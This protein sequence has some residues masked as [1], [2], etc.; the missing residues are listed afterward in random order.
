MSKLLGR[1]ATRAVTRPRPIVAATVF[2]AVIGAVLAAA[3][4]S[5]D[6]GTRTL[7][8]SGSAAFEGTER[9]KERFG[10]DAVVVLVKGD[11]SQLV[12]GDDLGR[13]LGL[14]GC[15]SGQ[16]PPDQGTPAGVCREIAALDPVR[17][18]YGPATFLNQS[19][20]QANRFLDEQTRAALDDAR[21]A[22]QRAA[23]SAAERGA[24]PDEQRRESEAAA[25]AVLSEYG[26]EIV[27]L[28]AEF[29]QTGLPRLDDPAFVSAIVFDSR[30]DDGTPKARF[31][32]LFP[33][34]EAALI[35]VRLRPELSDDER[36]RAIDL[37]R[38]AVTDDRFRL[39]GG[40]YV[41]SGVPVVL[42]GLADE[43]V[44]ETLV[45]LAIALVVMALVLMLVFGRPLRL[46][47]LAIALAASGL[48][49][50]L[51]AALGGSLTMASVAVLPVLIGLAVDYA[52]QLHARYTEA[53]AG[54]LVPGRAAV[55][56]AVSGGPV[57]G[58]AAIATAA[59]FA[60]LFGSP[61]PMVRGFG[62]MLVAGVGFAFA[63]A[64]TAGLGALSL[65]SERELDPSGS[66]RPPRP[67]ARGRV[68]PVDRLFVWSAVVR[69]HLRA[70]LEVAGRRVRGWAKA[71]LA[72]SIGA[73]IRV[74]LI[75]AVLAV[76]G[77]AAGTRTEVVS[78][79]RE[80][81]PDSLPAIEAVDELQ[82]ATGVSGEIDVLISGPG[83]TDPEAIVW[84]REFRARVLERNGFAGDFPDCRAPETELCP[85]IA[86]PDLFGSEGA[87]SRREVASVLRAVPEY[88]SQAVLASD[89]SGSDPVAS[90]AFG[91]R[92]MPLA[93]QKRLIDDLRAQIDPADADGP[94]PGVEAEL[95]G[96][97][98]LAAD[99]NEELS[100]SRYWL[101]LF[102][103]LAVAAVLA[104]VYRSPGR[105]LVPLIPIALATGWSALVL[106][107]M[108]VPLNPMSA[109]LG[110]LV[111]AIATEFSVILS[112]RFHEERAAGRSVGEALRVTY[113][114]TGIAVLASG[115]TA[116]AGFAVLITS[117]ITMLREFGLVTVVDLTVA[118]AGVMLVLPAA[119]VWAEGGFRPFGHLLRPLRGAGR[120]ASEPSKRSG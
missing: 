91:I 109:T 59:G 68:M 95:V 58:T 4:L 80:L 39:D 9:F 22:G 92:E 54:G 37:I 36:R 104:A 32:Y 10:D 118:L 47:P 40:S 57:I 112:A 6:A 29:G 97:P 87:P 103:L 3:R 90:I 107:A 114:R 69:E 16:A 55:A 56:A 28:A 8:D 74:L 30:R 64:L 19:A 48:T 26:D 82:A 100:G 102:S 34:S 98:V 72:V 115:V 41:V 83:V 89:E 62:L 27:A 51:L 79:I 117:G 23:A 86:L 63:I 46:L 84:M 113:S 111:I 44:G 67:G 99:A 71:A 25:A 5:P 93:D 81:V 33:S 77:W 94:P 21:T 88:F 42:E 78:D 38:D 52:I 2:L 76:A 49:F 35:S 14:E 105:V 110:A 101:T 70:P 20:I 1:V 11:L 108:G 50:G 7:L 15:L 106:A 13:L 60:V 119:L 116:I 120:G 61:I 53:I 65:A 96:L 31:A 73:P 18:V 45:A 24:P 43:L 85:A 66:R 17:V 75:A 12:L